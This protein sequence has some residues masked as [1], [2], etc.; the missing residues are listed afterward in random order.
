MSKKL[1]NNE[2]LRKITIAQNL[3]RGDVLQIFELAGHMLSFNQVGA[4][5]VSSDNRKFMPLSH[6]LLSDFLDKL[7]IYSRGTKEQ[8]HIPPKAIQN[9]IID[10]A[11]RDNLVGL[12]NIVTCIETAKE[13]VE[14]ARQE[15][16]GE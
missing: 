4:Y 11:E 5:L 7:I 10:L 2:I 6:E 16:S 3:R 12:E 14:Q 8:P 1:S 13:A 9:V 15:E